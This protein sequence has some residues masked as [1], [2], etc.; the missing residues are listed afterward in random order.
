MVHEMRHTLLENITIVSFADKNVLTKAKDYEGA[1]WFTHDIDQTNV[2][3]SIFVSARP[4]T[5]NNIA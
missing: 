4:N 1:V 3:L 2:N 5:L